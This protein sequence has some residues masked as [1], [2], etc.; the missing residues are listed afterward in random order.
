MP[1][2]QKIELAKQYCLHYHEGQLRKDKSPYYTHPFTVA[3]ILAKYGYDDIVTLCTAYLHDTGED[4]KIRMDEIEKVFGYEVSNGV[5][6]LSRNKGKMKDGEKLSREDYIQRLFWARKKIKRVKIAD[7]IHNSET[8][9]E[10]ELEKHEYIIKNIIS[11]AENF[12]IPWGREIAPIMVEELVS[13]IANYYR[14]VEQL[15]Q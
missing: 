6:I 14:K 2:D 5:Y 1:D 9:I 7:V 3:E 15:K 8:M 12:Y 13:N 4:S 10:L 11:D